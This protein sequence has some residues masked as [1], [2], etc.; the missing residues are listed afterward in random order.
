[1]NT[2]PPLPGTSLRTPLRWLITIYVLLIVLNI[3]AGAKQQPYLPTLLQRFEQEKAHAKPTFSAGVFAIEAIATLV[4]TIIASVALWRLRP[5]GRGMFVASVGLFVITDALSPPQ[6]AL[7]VISALDGVLHF[8][9]PFH[10]LP[11]SRRVSMSM[12]KAT[13]C[14]PASV[15][16]SRS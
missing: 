8:Y 10:G 3:V 15:E 16:E 5:S 6:V 7:G 4:L 11:P 14:R 13:K 2:P 1:M 9:I 12:A